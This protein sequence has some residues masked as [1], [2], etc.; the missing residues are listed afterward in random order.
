VA[1]TFASTILGP[2]HAPEDLV[3]TVEEDGVV[4][5]GDILFAGRIP[6]VGNADSKRWLA[7]IDTLAGLKAEGAGHGAWQALD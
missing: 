3:L 5:C 6:F 1:C 2:A 4:F 7:A